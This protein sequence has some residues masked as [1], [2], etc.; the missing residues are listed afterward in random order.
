M[1]LVMKVYVLDFNPR[2]PFI[3][4]PHEDIPFYLRVIICI[5]VVF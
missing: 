4:M 2:K 5:I 3:G 1:M